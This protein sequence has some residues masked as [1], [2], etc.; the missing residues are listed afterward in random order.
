MSELKKLALQILSGLEY[1]HECKIMYLD[2]KVIPTFF[3]LTQ[4][5]VRELIRYTGVSQIKSL[6]LSDFGVSKLN[7]E[8]ATTVTGTPGFMAPEVKNG[9][10]YTYSADSKHQNLVLTDTLFSFLFWC[11]DI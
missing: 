5:S 11:C 4:F 10:P 8:F 9:Q 6:H 1:L 7:A 3:H 2:L